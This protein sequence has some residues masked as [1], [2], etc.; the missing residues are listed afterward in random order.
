MTVTASAHDIELLAATVAALRTAGID[1]PRFEARRLIAHAPTA[2]VLAALLARRCAREPMA[3]I[4]GTQGF[5]TL[6]FE[7]SPATLIPRPDSETL[8][9]AALALPVRPGSILDLGTG[10]G[11]LLLAALAEFPAAWGVGVDL[12]AEAVSLAARNARANGL[13]DRATFLCGSWADAIGARFDLVLA[14]P[15]YIRSGDIAGLMPEVGRHEPASALDGGPDGLDAY[16]HILA[17]LP[18]LLTRGGH[19]IVELGIHQADA[20]ADLAITAGFGAPA[21]RADLGGIARALI[22]Q[23]SFGDPPA[24]G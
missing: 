5:W 4:L 9:E 1:N 17:R 18:T 6:D 15:P 11:C 23:N 16:R 14:N 12:V 2:D 10:T 8:I 21:S 19:A 22:V 20:V 7:V 13:A 24:T 3:F